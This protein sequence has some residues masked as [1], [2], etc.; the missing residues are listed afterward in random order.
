MVDVSYK[1][2]IQFEKVSDAELQ[3]IHEVATLA[4]Y[5]AYFGSYSYEELK[6]YLESFF[7]HE[8]LLESMSLDQH[9]Y[10]LVKKSMRGIGFAQVNHRSGFLDGSRVQSEDSVE[11]FKLYLLQ[12]YT[13]RGIG[14]RFMTMMTDYYRN[15]SYK[16]IFSTV[17]SLSPRALRFYKKNGFSVEGQLEYDYAGK[18]N[19]DLILKKE[20]GLSSD[21]TT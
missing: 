13:G 18:G 2:L 8:T 7:S 12:K 21:Q 5:Q 11:I 10:F 20:I 6:P 1:S 15:Y 16:N 3:S 19:I 14:T 4:Y 17:W 9:D